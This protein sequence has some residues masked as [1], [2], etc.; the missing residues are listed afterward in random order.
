MRGGGERKKEILEKKESSQRQM[1]KTER[2]MKERIKER[3]E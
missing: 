3:R 1:S 2:T